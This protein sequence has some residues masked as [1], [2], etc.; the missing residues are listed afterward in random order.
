MGRYNRRWGR[1]AV[2]GG[3]KFSTVAAVAGFLV[4]PAAVGMLATIATKPAAGA[5]AMTPQKQAQIFAG[6]HA[7]AAVAAWYGAKKFGAAHS[8]LRGAMYG[9]GVVTTL[10][11]YEM[12]QIPA[13]TTTTTAAPANASTAQLQALAN[14]LITGGWFKS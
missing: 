4:A 8:F 3:K 14:K 5:A 7:A 1:D 13:G 12:T 9:E 10:A 6:A 2:T 11:A